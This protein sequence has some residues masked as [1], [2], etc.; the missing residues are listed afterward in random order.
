MHLDNEYYTY[1]IGHRTLNIGHDDNG[2]YLMA[3][4]MHAM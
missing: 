4:N 3:G 2:A 1:S